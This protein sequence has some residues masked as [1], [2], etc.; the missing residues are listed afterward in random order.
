MK[1]DRLGQGGGIRAYCNN[2][3][4]DNVKSAR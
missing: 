4:T 2:A 3:M 1:V